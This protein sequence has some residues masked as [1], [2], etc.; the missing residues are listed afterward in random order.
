MVRD[1]ADYY[2]AHPEMFVIPI[3]HLSRDGMSA[4]FATLV[5]Q[6]TTLGAEWVEGF[7]AAFRLYWERLSEL[8]VRAPRDWFP[9]RL[10]HCC[11]VTAPLRVRPYFQPFN[12]SSWLLHASDFDPAVSDPE[13][14]AYQLIHAERMGLLQ[15]VTQPVLRNLSYWLVRSDE[16]IEAFCAACRRSPRP[17]AGAFRALADAMPWIR[18]L[19]HDPLKRPMLATVEP[20]VPV[21]GT[22]L[23]LPRSAQP[24]LE[25]L[26][27]RWRVAAEAAVRG[28]H[29]SYA[30][31]GRDRAGELCAWLREHRPA[32]LLT[33]E[34]G[35]TLW[36]PRASDETS[37]VRAALGG[38]GEAA[39]AS[40]RADVEVIHA[41]SSRFLSS[42]ASPQALPAPHPDTAQNGLCYLHVSRKLIAYNLREPGM[43]RLRV[44][45]PPYERFMLGAR[46]LHEWGHLAVEAGWVP[47]AA[48]RRREFDAARDQL[49]ALF[50]AGYRAAP[51][52]LRQHTAAA[53]A[54]L[55]RDAGGLG[56]GLADIAVRRLPDYQANL[57]ARYYL[58]L[59]ERETYIR[60]NVYALVR[61]SPPPAIF[62]RLARALFESQYLRFSDVPDVRRYFLCSTWFTEDYMA[63]GALTEA[64]LE[65]LLAVVGRLCDC[66]AVD[67]TKF[68]PEFAAAVQD[69]SRRGDPGGV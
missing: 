42:L 22:G 59:A 54:Q 39:A 51:G 40:I 13:F 1:L 3:E 5:R 49:A 2:F 50:E 16:E 37:A 52:R 31:R 66:V 7:N 44:P 21:P 61:E 17:D 46:V 10:Q 48:E 33:G 64:L 60:N 32:T 18:R 65:P 8:A 56:R 58:T 30:R 27:R 68:T 14:G 6:R 19:Y 11:A 4:A 69:G 67:W 29:D 53:M 26:Q 63:A 43:E 24:Q 34:L 12:K 9:P 36:D 57:L 20:S 38:V 28:F 47:V 25:A 15:E 55:A 23:L 35:E 62:Q 41:H 45:A